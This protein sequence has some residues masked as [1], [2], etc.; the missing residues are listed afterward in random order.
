MSHSVNIGT[1][2]SID[3]FGVGFF[4]LFQ[5]NPISR[6]V[7]K[8]KKVVTKKLTTKNPRTNSAASQQSTGPD[9]LVF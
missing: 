7:E 9:Y 5:K 6:K 4:D 3:F 2:E 8:K 1:K